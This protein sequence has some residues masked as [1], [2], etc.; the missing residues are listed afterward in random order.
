M[1]AVMRADIM[2]MRYD[3]YE[4]P[5]LLEV[6]NKRFSALI[7]IHSG[8]FSC[9]LIHGRIIIDDNDLLQVMALSNFKII[10][11][12]CRCDLH[13]SGTELLIYVCVCNDRNLASGRRQYEHLSDN[14]L[15]TLILRIDRNCSISE[16]CLRSGCCDLYKT[17]LLTDYRIV[18]V[19]EKSILLLML[20]LCI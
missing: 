9:F 7:P 6:C 12:M 18:N 3:L 17:T 19:P 4:Q 8:I 15:I 2:G 13:T 14:I 5:H 1:A 20:Y 11:V 16:Q 10:R